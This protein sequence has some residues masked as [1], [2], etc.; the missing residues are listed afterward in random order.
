MNWQKLRSKLNVIRDRVASDRI[1]LTNKDRID[2]TGYEA[3]DSAI[4]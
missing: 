4:D 2:F 3:R 1:K